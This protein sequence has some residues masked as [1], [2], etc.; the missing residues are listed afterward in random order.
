MQAPRLEMAGRSSW[1]VEWWRSGASPTLDSRGGC[2][3]IRAA[4]SAISRSFF[5]REV[6]VFSVRKPAQS[7]GVGGISRARVPEPHLRRD[8][9]GTSP[10]AG[11]PRRLSP[12]E[13]LMPFSAGA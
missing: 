2:R 1:E 13:L 4:G 7:C 3:H 8:Y 12:H 10:L 9:G 11:Q 6:G 5:E